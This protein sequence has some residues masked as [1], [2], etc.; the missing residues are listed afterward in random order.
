MMQFIYDK[1]SELKRLWI[2][3]LPYNQYISYKDVFENTISKQWK[4]YISNHHLESFGT[5][6]LYDKYPH[7]YLKQPYISD[8]WTIY[9]LV[10]VTIDG[11]RYLY[12]TQRAN[13]YDKQQIDQIY[14]YVWLDVSQKILDSRQQYSIVE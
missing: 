3:T 1:Q 10:V 5:S 8:D 7:E 11:K 14:Y 4:N 9:S 6:D 13:F 2:N 12:A